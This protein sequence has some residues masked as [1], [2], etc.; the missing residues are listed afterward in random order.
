MRANIFGAGLLDRWER[1]AK[2]AV[3]G[4]SHCSLHPTLARLF[5]RLARHLRTTTHVSR[6]SSPFDLNAPYKGTLSLGYIELL[7]E[8]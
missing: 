6:T 5:T 7:I 1:D 4:R 8:G 3:G 2:E